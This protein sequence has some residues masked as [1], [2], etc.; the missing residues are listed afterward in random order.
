MLEWDGGA[1]ATLIKPLHSQCEEVRRELEQRTGSSCSCAH[2]DLDDRDSVEGFVQR[3]RKTSHGVVGQNRPVSVLVNCAG[4]MGVSSGK[5]GWH[6]TFRASSADAAGS[7]G[8]AWDASKDGHVGPNHLGPFL[9]TWRLLR[10]RLIGP[11]SRCPGEGAAL[12][13]ACR[14]DA[15]AHVASLFSPRYR[16]ARRANG[17]HRTAA[18]PCRC[19]R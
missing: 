7:S 15:C 17:P 8:E 14:R 3:F 5:R 10:D 19:G 2:L 1:W 6:E 16:S 13:L 18:R 11:G 12:S 4:V 9:L